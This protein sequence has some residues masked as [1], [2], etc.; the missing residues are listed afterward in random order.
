M[1]RSI[2][3]MEIERNELQKQLIE[4]REAQSNQKT[5]RDLKLSEV[6]TMLNTVADELGKENHMLLKDA[7]GSII[8]TVIPDEASM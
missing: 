2:E 8:D 7:L 1:L 6:K 3:K 4:Y 5:F